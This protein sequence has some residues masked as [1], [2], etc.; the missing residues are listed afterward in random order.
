MLLTRRRKITFIFLCGGLR[1]SR[2]DL[3]VCIFTC[4]TALC[5]YA[6]PRGAGWKEEE[7]ERAHERPLD[8]RLVCMD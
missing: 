6:Y 4:R 3:E 5:C 7:T 1:V 2:K 8:A